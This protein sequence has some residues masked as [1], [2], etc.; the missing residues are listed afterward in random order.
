M[1][2]KTN[3]TSETKCLAVF[4]IG[5]RCP[6]KWRV[7]ILG[8]LWIL[9]GNANFVLSIKAQITRTKIDLPKLFFVN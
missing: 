8:L 6:L 1:L 3:Y 7:Q 4:L 2:Q 5:N 9:L